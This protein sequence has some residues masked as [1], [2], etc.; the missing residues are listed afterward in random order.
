MNIP[1]YTKEKRS[2]EATNKAKGHSFHCYLAEFSLVWSRTKG[3][4]GFLLWIEPLGDTS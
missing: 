4:V 1:E 2:M 3:S